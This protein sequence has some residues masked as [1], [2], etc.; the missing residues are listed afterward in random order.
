MPRSPDA[1][2]PDALCEAQACP[3]EAVTATDLIVTPPEYLQELHDALGRAEQA[4]TRENPD[5]AARLAEEGLAMV[6]IAETKLGPEAVPAHYRAFFHCLHLAPAFRAAL[7]H[8]KRGL[9][10]RR[11]PGG[12]TEDAFR[13]AWQIFGPAVAGLEEGLAVERLTYDYPVAGRVLRGAVRLREQ[14]RAHLRL[15]GAAPREFQI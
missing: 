4:Y 7:A 6:R 15:T 13:R 10:C 9:L 12:E 2:P 5:E 14:L 8:F 1:Q 3:T 11:R